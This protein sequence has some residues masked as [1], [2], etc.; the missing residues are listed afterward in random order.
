MDS[1]L[2]GKGIVTGDEIDSGIH[3]VR[4]E[5]QVPGQPIKLGNDQCCTGQLAAADGLLKFRSL[6]L[7]A[8]LD[9]DIFLQKLTATCDQV[10]CNCLSLGIDPV[11][12]L[13]LL[14]GGHP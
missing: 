5:G 12:L 10:V 9:F 3:E 7:F 1:Q 2:V 6:I 4:D 11:T 13:A 14:V 8:A